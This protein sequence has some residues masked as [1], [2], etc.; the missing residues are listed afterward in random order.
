M[1]CLT[2]P[3]EFLLCEE[4]GDRYHQQSDEKASEHAPERRSDAYPVKP[5]QDAAEG[6]DRACKEVCDGVCKHRVLAAAAQAAS[7]DMPSEL[8]REDECSGEGCH[9]ACGEHI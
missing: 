9:A 2:S 1:C 8:E 3:E 4:A 6:E 5:W 7:L